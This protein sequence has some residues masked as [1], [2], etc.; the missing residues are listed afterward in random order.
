MCGGGERPSAYLLFPQSL[1]SPR[2]MMKIK[3][4]GP[5]SS[6]RERGPKTRSTWCFGRGL[7]DQPSTAIPLHP[8]LNQNTGLGCQGEVQTASPPQSKSCRATTE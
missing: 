3:I 5:F 7:R 6:P 1:G 4:P 8:F 2:Q